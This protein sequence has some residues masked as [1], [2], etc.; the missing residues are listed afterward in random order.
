MFT[1]RLAI[2]VIFFAV[3]S[4][5]AQSQLAIKHKEKLSHELWR[6]GQHIDT[7]FYSSFT[8][9]A[10]DHRTLLHTIKT[11]YPSAV[12]ISVYAPA[13]VIVVRLKWGQLVQL[14][15]DERV[16]FADRLRQPK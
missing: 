13:H 7:N 8:I 3:A 12:V 15:A 14:L 16:I 4:V 1:L 2:A 10:T 9:A 5:H 11:I 6:Q